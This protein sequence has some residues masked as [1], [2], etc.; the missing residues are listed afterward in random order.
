VD[1]TLAAIAMIVVALGAVFGVSIVVAPY[2]D[3]NV[4]GVERYQQIGRYILLSRGKPSGWGTGGTPTELGLAAGGNPYELDIDKVTRLN[5]DHSQSLNYSTL[6]QALGIDDVSFRISVEPLFNLTLTLAS[7]QVQG[8][9]T[10][11]D[12]SA[13]TMRDGFPLPCQVSYYVAVG[14]STYSSSG[15]TTLGGSGNV[16]F[17]LPNSL[18][19]TALLIG[20][21]RAESSI[22]SFDV[23]PFAHNIGQPSQPGAFTSLSSVDYTLGVSLADGAA[24][25]NAAVFSH[26]Y[27]FNLTAS[28]SD[29]IIPWL[30]DGGLMVVTLTGINGTDRWAEWVA[31]PQIPF[32]V[33]GDMDNDYVVSDVSALEY[34]VEIEGGLYRFRMNFRS[35]AEYD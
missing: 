10:V 14:N 12:F 22:T 15:S 24:T 26:D 17:A 3:G 28:G 23:L 29:Y 34:V 4:H 31:Y 6:W 25:W 21:A 30:L 7:S 2:L 20:I 35:P 16:L 32:E 19:G 5:P 8:S 33:G 9:D 18:N 1:F 27:S 11:Y 13:T